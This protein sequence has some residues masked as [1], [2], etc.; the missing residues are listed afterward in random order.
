MTV[1]DQLTALTEFLLL[2]STHFPQ[3]SYLLIPQILQ[4][5]TTTLTE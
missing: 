1:T 3:Q 2:T 5:D 4:Y